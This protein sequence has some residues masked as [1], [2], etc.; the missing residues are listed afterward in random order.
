[1]GKVKSQITVCKLSRSRK[2]LVKPHNE[3]R[4][5]EL[6]PIYSERQKYGIN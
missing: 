4:F 1:L 5:N 3:G 6:R 2:A